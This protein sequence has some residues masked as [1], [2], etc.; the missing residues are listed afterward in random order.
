MSPVHV[1]RLQGPWELQPLERW[2]LVSD[3]RRLTS[4]EPLPAAGPLEMPADWS[5]RLGADFC[6]R[7]RH[8]RRFGRPTRLVAG[9][10]VWLVCE[11]ATDRATVTLNGAALGTIAGP[12][13]QARF[14]ITDRLAPR[15]ELVIDVE[16]PA[17]PSSLGASPNSGQLSAELSLPAPRALPR[18]GL[19][20]KVRL[21]IEE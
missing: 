21:E 16:F 18:G 1:I 11:G 17:A 7:V 3:G 13:A 5:Q 8:R 20:G 10:R 9:Q 4:A 12:G 6:G 15:C 2:T 19:T 14:D